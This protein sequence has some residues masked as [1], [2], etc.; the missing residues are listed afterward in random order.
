MDT[1]IE[2]KPGAAVD[3]QSIKKAVIED[4][5]DGDIALGLAQ[6]L[7]AG[8]ESSPAVER[9]VLRK[10]DF[11]LLP[12]ISCTATLSFLD[13]VSNN[14]ANN[15]GLATDLGMV[16]T[17]FSWSASIFYFAFL[18]WQPA[19]SYILQHYPLGK[20]I[21]VRLAPSC[22]SFLPNCGIC[23]LTWPPSRSTASVGA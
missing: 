12:L 6:E 16:G 17:Q 10:I 1:K 15:Y 22:F 19:V 3:V 13:K 11:I 2:E 14:Y 5:G 18:I 20:V 9:R 4:H 7:D 8:Y 23:L 21:S